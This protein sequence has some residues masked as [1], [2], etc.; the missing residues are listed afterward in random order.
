MIARTLLATALL[1]TAPALA[2][3][4]PA[5]A[6]PE[7]KIHN[8][9]EYLE[10]VVDD[11]RGVFIRGYT[12]QWYYARTRTDCPRLRRWARLGF[13]PSP[14][15]DFDQR[16]ALRADGWRCFIASVTESEGPPR[17]ARR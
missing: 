3:D 6:R 8:M 11:R 16:S 4:T 9:S 15:G 10:A 5:D 14:G 17:P 12:G 2:L 13:E 7:V 1:G